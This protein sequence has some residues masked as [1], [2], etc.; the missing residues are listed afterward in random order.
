MATI[1]ETILNG[2]LSVPLAANDNSKGSLF[3]GRLS[4]PTS[5]V[6]IAMV[7]DALNWMYGSTG[8]YTDQEMTAVANY[9]IWLMGKYGLQASN[10]TGSGGSV[11][12]IVPGG[13]TPSRIDFEVSASSYMVTGA[14]SATISQFV[15]R[16]IDFI[17]G[18]ISQSTLSSQP[19]YITWTKATGALTVSPALAATEIIA[20]IP[21]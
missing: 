1:P 3:G 14:T 6:T 11:T 8:S 4:S 15:G 18:G 10:I 20:I 7:T 16:E 12:P 5:P 19:S 13:L 9:L 21:S 17:R 2:E